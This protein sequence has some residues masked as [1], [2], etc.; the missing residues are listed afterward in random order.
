MSERVPIVDELAKM[1]NST[2]T[3]FQRMNQHGDLI[4]IAT[5]VT[6]LDG[7][8]A[9]G[10]YIPAINA[11]GSPNAV[12]QAILSGREY[13]GTAYV[14]NKWYQTLYKPLTDGAG[15]V[16]GMI[17]TGVTLDNAVPELRE[18][19]LKTQ[20]GETGYVYV[21]S[22]SGARKGEYLISKDGKKDGEN[23]FDAKD[24]NGRLFI[25]EIIEKAVASTAGEILFD[26]Y[27]WQ[28]LDEDQPR[29]KVVA[30]S[31]FKPFDWV[32]GSGVYEEEIYRAGELA[33]KS[34][35]QVILYSILAL[36]VAIIIMV[37]VSNVISSK[38]AYPIT[39]SAK[40]LMN[41]ANGNIGGA[42]Q[43]L[44]DLS[45]WYK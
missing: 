13:R 44:K 18:S 33:Q 42:K 25:Q 15:N 4:R 8:R 23:I 20:V 10:T 31:Y 12:V 11:D 43:Q 19:I 2:F 32:I 27:P 17:Y 35:S 38:I 7:K 30:F 9:V 1:H 21:L 24:A 3:I 6:T 26:S 41:L 36:A 14:V 22:G 28:N 45:D 16:I 40:I 5:N 34:T 37:F 39:E 29:N